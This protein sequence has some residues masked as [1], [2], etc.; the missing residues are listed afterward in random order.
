MDTSVATFQM[1]VEF[2]NTLST[3]LSVRNRDLL[4]EQIEIIHYLIK[5]YI[6][7]IE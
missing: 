2:T 7:S 6:Y 3:V 4:T 5:S 1:E